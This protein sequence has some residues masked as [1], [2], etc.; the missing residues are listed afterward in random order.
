MDL[1]DLTLPIYDGTASVESILFPP[2]PPDYF[3]D[4]EDAIE[5]GN[6]NPFFNK[7]KDESHPSVKPYIQSV[8]LNN[9]EDSPYENRPKVAYEMGLEFSF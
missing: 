9:D 8:D 3:S 5:F 7:R 6:S 4:K 1:S 2:T